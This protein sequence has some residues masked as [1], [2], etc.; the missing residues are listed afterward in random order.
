MF[1]TLWGRGTQVELAKREGC[2][3]RKGKKKKKQEDPDK[4]VE[5]GKKE[6]KATSSLQDARHNTVTAFGR[7]CIIFFRGFRGR[8]RDGREWNAGFLLVG[9]F[10]TARDPPL[11]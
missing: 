3:E 6:E 9:L 2:N 1:R 4:R 11:R 10:E 8:R 7:V 5:K